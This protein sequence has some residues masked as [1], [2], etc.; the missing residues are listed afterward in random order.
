MKCCNG[1]STGRKGDRK[2]ALIY[3]LGA[4]G[5]FLSKAISTESTEE[6]VRSSKEG[7]EGMGQGWSIE[8]KGRN[9]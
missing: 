3:A 8:L 2:E 1:L 9:T 6:D 5:R 4:S 7:D